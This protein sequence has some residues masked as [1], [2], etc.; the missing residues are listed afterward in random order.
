L[1][2]NCNMHLSLAEE[3]YLKTIYSIAEKSKGGVSTNDIAKSLKTKASSV[4]DMYKKLVNKGLII[5][6]K[7]KPIELS[8]KGKELATTLI[9]KHRLW[10]TFLVEKLDFDWS[11][12]H[13]I[14]EQLE[15]IKSDELVE[16]L[17]KFLGNPLYDP[18]GDPIPD[19][20]GKFPQRNQRLLSTLCKGESGILSS[21]EIDDNEFLEMLNNFEIEIGTKITVQE[22]FDLDKSIQVKLNDNHK[23][24]LSKTMAENLSVIT[25]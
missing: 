22:I 10:E 14:A 12:V 18:H 8:P 13:F 3:N 20:N 15:H 1:P 7:Y 9:R 23:T 24:L 16:K 4:T 11:K 19:K 25:S 2:K 5:Y 17:D 6:Q 21:V